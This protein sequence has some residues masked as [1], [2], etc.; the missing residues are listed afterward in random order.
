MK[1]HEIK[2][3]GHATGNTYRA[4]VTFVT[5]GKTEKAAAKTA[6]QNYR[7]TYSGMTADVAETDGVRQT[8]GAGTVLWKRRSYKLPKWL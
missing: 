2:I 8:P 5:E 6:L 7:A 1:T 4:L 3:Y